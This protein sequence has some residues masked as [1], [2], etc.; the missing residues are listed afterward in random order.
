MLVK[1]HSRKR[2]ELID[3]SLSRNNFLNFSFIYKTGL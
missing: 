1:G 2:R 3:K